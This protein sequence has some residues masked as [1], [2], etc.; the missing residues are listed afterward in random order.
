MT[1]FSALTTDLA[2]T[3]AKPAP[4]VR[5]AARADIPEIVAIHKKA[6]THFFLSRMGGDFLCRYY[7]LVLKYQH[8]IVVVGEALG[9]V[10]GFACGFVD[11]TAFY[12]LMRHCSLN[13]V[14]PTARAVLR[15]PSLL[16]GIARGVQRIRQ[17]AARTAPRSCDL[18]SI[19]VAPEAG[20]TGLGFALAQAFLAQAWSMNA[21]LVRLYTDAHRN[22]AAHALYRKLGFREHRLFLQYKGRWMNEYIIFRGNDPGNVI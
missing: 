16:G 15:H 1:S 3:A 7:E 13:F 17:A 18:S 14:L 20:R 12:T 5:L 9:R 22:E 19:A 21:N 4:T 10:Q 11:P 8:G 2:G 6:F